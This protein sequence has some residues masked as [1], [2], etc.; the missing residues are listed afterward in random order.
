[1]IRQPLF[2]VLVLV[3]FVLAIPIHATC[4]FRNTLVDT[5]VFIPFRIEMHKD[6]M[7]FSPWLHRASHPFFLFMPEIISASVEPS[8]VV[9]GNTM[10]IT[11]EIRD[12][13]GLKTVSADMGS[14]ETIQLKLVS[15]SA[16]HG[17]WK[18]AWVVHSTEQKDYITRI[19]AT[20]FIGLSSSIDVIWSDP[21]LFSANSSLLTATIN[22]G[23][24]TT[25]YGNC[26][27]TEE[28]ASDVNIIIQNSTSSGGPFTDTPTNSNELI[29]VNITSYYIGS[30]L[31]SSDNYY[32]NITANKAGTYYFRVRCNSTNAEPMEANSTQSSLAVNQAYGYLNV[33]LSNPEPAKTTNIIQNQTFLI[34]ANVSCASSNPTAICD[35][36]NGTARYNL[37]ADPD[38]PVNTTEGDV[39]LWTGSGNPQTCGV[40]NISSGLCNLTWTV[41]ATG[42]ISSS[43]KIDVL[44]SSN[45]T[46]V[47]SNDTDDAIISIRSCIVD[48]TLKWSSISFGSLNPGEK[49]IAAP[50]NSNKTYNITVNSGSCN[51]DIYVRGT[52]LFNTTLGTVVGVGNISWS[53]VTDSYN[54][55][56][57]LTSTNAAIEINTIENL[58][59]YIW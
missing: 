20:D 46:G 43:W 6:T 35:E 27:V 21:P 58:L 18:G 13:F 31:G 4:H 38:T 9:T 50:G 30:L 28:A 49:G 24:N 29:Y 51:L 36:V 16:Y 25:L 7:G 59:M 11:A 23:E 42:P 14:I 15:G 5:T 34:I 3:V 52:N 2:Y 12:T 44:F 37:T 19:T 54:E 1:M 40:V 17:V 39:P 57:N 45:A 32:F 47:Q 55:A 48:F 53:N 26:T 8:K 41:N 33:T 56:F 22:T 10:T